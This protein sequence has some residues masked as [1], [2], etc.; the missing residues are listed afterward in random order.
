MADDNALPEDGL[1]DEQMDQMAS[2]QG[3]SP[4]AN[5]A[6]P[7]DG[8]T[9][10]QM[11]QLSAGQPESSAM[12][13]AGRSF[14]RGILPNTAAA[15]AGNVAGV[16]AGLAA[17]PETGPAAPFI[18][19]AAAAA[20]AGGVGYVATR[21]QDAIAKQLGMDLGPQEQADVTQHPYASEFG[22]WASLLATF[23]LGGIETKLA[24][25]AITGGIMGGIDLTQQ[26][27]N[28]GVGNIDPTEAAIAVGGGALLGGT[29]SWARGSERIGTQLGEAFRRNPIRTTVGEGGVA[30]RPN[31]PQQ[32]DAV[33]L[34]M[35]T[36]KNDL[37]MVSRGVAQENIAPTH[38]PDT[39]QPE[40]DPSA[41]IDVVRSDMDYKKGKGLW[42]APTEGVE[43]APSTPG[44]T[45]DD[46]PA[47]DIQAALGMQ[48]GAQGQPTAPNVPSRAPPQ[49]PIETGLAALNPARQMLWQRR[50]PPKPA[51]AQGQLG[52]D[53]QPEPTP[54][55]LPGGNMRDVQ[56]IRHGATDL[57]H[58]DLSVDKLRGWTN[59]P[60]SEAGRAEATKT[61]EDVAKSPPGHIITSDLDRAHET[62]KIV[63]AQ[64]GVPIVGVTPNLRPW[65]VGDLAGKPSKDGIPILADYATNHPNTPVPGGESF[66]QF[67]SRFFTGLDNILDHSPN[68][69]AI[70][71][72]HRGE[73]LM[74]SW[75]DAGYPADGSIDMNTF[76]QKGEPTG[77][78][79]DLQLPP[80]RVKAA[81]QALREQAAQPEAGVQPIA[82]APPEGQTAVETTPREQQI[83]DSLK[84]LEGGEEA[85]GVL[86]KTTGAQREA[87]FAKAAQAVKNAPEKRAKVGEVQTG[88][89]ARGAR[90]TAAA[91]AVKDAYEKFAPAADEDD[92][93]LL[94]RLK[95][96]VDH[97]TD[98]YGGKNPVDRKEGYA[99]RV[100][101]PEWQFI[102]KA[103]AVL[104]KPTDANIEQFRTDEGLLRSGGAADVQATK[105]IT[106]DIEK[107]GTPTAETA[108]AAGA[109]E[110]TGLPARQDFDLMEPWKPG[111]DESKQY[112]DQSNDLR[113][114]I[115]G[116]DEGD[117]NKL[118]GAYPDIKEVVETA[119]DPNRLRLQMESD[120]E[121]A[122]MKAA[123]PVS[124][125]PPASTVTEKPLTTEPGAAASQGVSRKDLIAEY[126]AKLKAGQLPGGNITTPEERMPQMNFAGNKPAAEPQ[127]EP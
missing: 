94:D 90:K 3:S 13:A 64:T 50:L 113:T 15:L 120:L 81:A 31:Q 22:D 56:I 119:G 35:E 53:F 107:R 54:A 92:Q 52:L 86:E 96:A 65:N 26:A 71:I 88:G 25:R 28:K 116:L 118:A 111:A 95:G 46:A 40:K 125:K 32:P 109:A 44:I 122:Q 105:R 27:A 24:Q 87:A 110:S 108:E 17:L 91:A 68:K 33:D 42:L 58:D 67:R 60:L 78:A 43:G 69:P 55:Q 12:G 23:N 103:Q 62:A 34:R 45:F 117:Y 30:G 115:N 2:S 51:A 49:A 97:A 57:N 124:P 11:D 8:L 74:K 102:K 47:A 38:Q 63:S 75:A 82:K 14:V 29:R 19:G 123:A 7:E 93:A 66:N 104:A 100:K 79:E 37:T 59:V 6:V 99:P 84:N 21:A 101:P 77:K 9:D 106:A 83:L 36:N 18:G 1:T 10:E 20:V 112:I 5:Q 76:N 126:N 114:W 16:G 80:D 39:V 70:V 4:Q 85:A 127:P 61:S 48:Q 72:H 73:R 41:T 98:Q 89:G 121:G